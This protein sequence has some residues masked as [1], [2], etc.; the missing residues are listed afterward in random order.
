MAGGQ[1]RYK[2]L[3]KGML[4]KTTDEKLDANGKSLV[5]ERVLRDATAASANLLAQPLDEAGDH[6]TDEI[7]S[8]IKQEA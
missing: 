3:L 1:Q 4:D 8:F 6:L 2:F 7:R 5:I